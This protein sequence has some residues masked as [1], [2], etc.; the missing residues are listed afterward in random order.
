MEEEA[1]QA[2]RIVVVT[3]GFDNMRSHQIRFLEEAARLGDAV[4]VLLWSDATFA[5]AT[6]KPPKFGQVERQYLVGAVRYVDAVTLV[7][8]PADRGTLAALDGLQPAVWAV[9][10][11][12]GEDSPDKAAYC[13][14]RSMDYR[15]VTAEDMAGFP[16][17]GYQRPAQAAATGSAPARKKVIVTGCYDWFHSGHVR[18]FEEVSELGDLYVVAGNDANVRL[19]KGAGH[20]LFHQ[21]ERR[22]VVGSVRYVKEALISSGRG[23]MDAEPEI[24]LIK[25]DIYAVNDDGDKPEKWQFCRE[26]GLEYVVLKRKPKEGLPQRQSTALRGF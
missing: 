22:Y 24:A 13:A 5:D 6:G 14:A 12:R 20:P 15:V 18:F 21:D 25:P 23:W 16:E 11:V 4:H 10:Q 1:K 8:G 2:K 17:V 26:H 19:L 7:H 3:G 9:D